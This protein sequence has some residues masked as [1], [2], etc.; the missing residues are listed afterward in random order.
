MFYWH[1]AKVVS[2]GVDSWA[3]Q[4]AAVETWLVDGCGCS[5]A[6]LDWLLFHSCVQHCIGRLVRSG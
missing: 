2:T 1:A 6:S 3:P 4:A 5:I